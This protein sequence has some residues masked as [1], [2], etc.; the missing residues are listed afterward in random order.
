MMTRGVQPL[1]PARILVL[2]FM[3]ISSVCRALLL[4]MPD[5]TAAT[6]SANLALDL[7]RV[8]LRVETRLDVGVGGM[9]RR[10]GATGANLGLDLH[11]YSPV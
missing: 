11:W 8:L 1:R 3:V 2:T 9:A 4:R 5:D 7:H 10:A 6:A